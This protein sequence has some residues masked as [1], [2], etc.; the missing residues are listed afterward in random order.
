[1]NSK[2]NPD[3]CNTKNFKIVVLFKYL[4]NYVTILY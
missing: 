4:D 1:M 3:E 2:K